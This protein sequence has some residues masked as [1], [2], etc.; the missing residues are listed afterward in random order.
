MKGLLIGLGV[1]VVLIV[2]ALLLVPVLVPK[3]ALEARIERAATEALGRTVTIEGTPD[4]RLFP[5]AL[6]V[7]GLT[8]AN[9]EGFDAP[10]FL[11]VGEADIGVKLLPLL[12]SRI[13]ITRFVLQEPEINLEATPEGEANWTFAQQEE[14]AGPLPDLRLGT[15]R[16]VN[17]AITYDGGTGQTFT[18]QDADITLQVPSLDEPLT[19]EGDLVF[20]NR[21]ARFTARV[22]TPRSLAETGQAAL[23]MTAAVA[24]NEFEAEMEL[25]EDLAFEGRFDLDAPRLRDLLALFG[26]TIEAPSGFERLLVTGQVT[27]NSEQLAFAEGTRVAFDAIEGTGALTLSLGGERP[28]I[29]GSFR[30]GVVDLRPYLPEEE[31]PAAQESEGFPAWSE[32]PLDLSVLT[33][34]DADIALS[35]ETILLPSIEVGESAAQVTL[36]GGDLSFVLDRLALYGGSGEGT[37]RV[38]AAGP[39]Q[40]VAAQFA[41]SGVD[42]AAFARNVMDVSRVAGTADLSLDLATA[43]DSQADF[44]RNLSGD[45]GAELT[46]G[47]I[48]GVDLGTIARSA[49]GVANSLRQG[50]LNLAAVTSAFA[51]VSDGALGAE[52]ETPFASLVV[53]LDLTEGV[54]QT[55]RLAL[56]G[57]FYSV[58]GEGSANLPNQTVRLV[59]RPSVSAEDGAARRELIA[60]ILVTGTFSDPKIGVDAEPLVRD[61]AGGAVREVLRG[62][63]VELGEDQSVGDALRG[64]ATQELGRLFG[65]GSDEETEGETPQDPEE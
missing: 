33:A 31:A 48:T 12:S 26:T 15:V 60:P 44:V 58:T 43:G 64:R 14:E 51:T 54:A 39:T 56:E 34:A 7:D 17:G 24:E 2:A 52:E 45:F 5:T 40:T 37:L 42:A 38:D 19:A 29:S 25:G 3:D 20:E 35:A 55:G 41:L 57:P 49:L 61:A 65:R 6:S 23:A 13:E 30:A 50:Q 4:I 22:E 18:A 11:R 1:L 28:D 10:Y 63:G 46:D 36:R 59:L 27:G 47:V 53:D 62:Q 32:E 9:A 8:V 16:I 21:P